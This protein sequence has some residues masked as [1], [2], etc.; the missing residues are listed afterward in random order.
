MSSREPINKVLKS[1]S[2]P[3]EHKQKLQLIEKVKLFAEQ[4]L[5][6]KKT[7]N[8]QHFVKLKNPYVSYLLTVSKKYD[9]KAYE[10]YFPIIGNVPYKGFPT[11]EKA[12]EEAQQF[13]KQDYDTYIRGASAYST[14][15]WF[16]DPVLS[17]MLEYDEKDLVDLI[18][19]E[20]VHATLFIKSEAE[21]N[22]RLASFIGY[23]GAQ[24]FY[25]KLEG[26]NS[27]NVQWLKD[28]N[29]DDIAFSKFLTS[30]TEKLKI[31][32][33]SEPVINENIKKQRLNSL[34]D[35][36]KKELQPKLKTKKYLWFLEQEINNAFLVG[37]M[38]Y[39]ANYALFEK[40]LSK[41]GSL[42]AFI[43]FCK[44]LEES[45]NPQEELIKHYQIE[46]LS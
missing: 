32:Y 43:E 9:L 18:I 16:D 45:E 7:S 20:S 4:H 33:K 23:K 39:N 21:F 2:L 24:E 46:E 22:E 29:Q 14:L 44:S 11:P 10:W 6:L 35:V 28:E 37:L 34:K 30:Q 36:F 41:E 26:E 13:S 38:T 27:K 5:G 8:Y 15:G 40:A 1:E 12:K 31:W 25:L 19:H 17:S 3:N 42:R